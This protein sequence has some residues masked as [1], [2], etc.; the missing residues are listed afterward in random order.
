MIGVAIKPV[1]M[2]ICEALHMGMKDLGYE[3]VRV[4]VQGYEKPTLEIIIDRLDGQV[5]GI[6]DCVRASDYASSVLDVVDPF[7]GAYTLQVFSP[8]AERPLTRTSDFQKFLGERVKVKLLVAKEGR[9]RLSGILEEAGS[10]GITLSLD[11]T[12]EVVNLNFEEMGQAKLS[13][14]W[15]EPSKGKKEA[16]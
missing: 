11:D 10:Q 5:V 9:K 15:E 13:P 6:D 3:I 12:R 8:G 7:E 1:E 14:L 4:Q 2:T 16:S